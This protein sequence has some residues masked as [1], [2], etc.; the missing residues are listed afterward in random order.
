M[1]WRKDD[2]G[3]GGDRSVMCA[4]GG[5]EVFL[6]YLFIKGGGCEGTVASFVYAFLF[7]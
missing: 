4:R 3:A 1:R 5:V 6:A 2:E 7:F